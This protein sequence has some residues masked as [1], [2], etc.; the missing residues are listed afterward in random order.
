MSLELARGLLGRGRSVRL[1][2]RGG[3]MWPWLRDGAVVR[4]D[5][6]APRRGEIAAAIHQGE[7]ILH[8]L[9]GESG[10]KLLLRG[11]AL[12][13]VERVARGAVIGA[14]PS[15]VAWLVPLTR[16]V[17]KLRRRLRRW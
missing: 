11:D 16:L 3:S 6:R 13:G 14:I 8:R 15:R 5:P 7:L 2:A 17:A 12:D 4:I 10:G 1:I 9:V